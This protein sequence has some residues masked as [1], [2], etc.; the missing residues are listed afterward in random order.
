MEICQSPHFI[1][2]VANFI[3]WTGDE[4]S[5]FLHI[6]SKAM[7]SFS[8]AEN[9]NQSL[10]QLCNLRL[11]NWLLPHVVPPL[12]W[13][14]SNNGCMPLNSSMRSQ[15]SHRTSRVHLILSLLCFT[16]CQLMVSRVPSLTWCQIS[17][18]ASSSELLWMVLSRMDFW[19][20][21]CYWCASMTPPRHWKM[22]RI[23][24]K[25]K[26]NLRLMEELEH[27]TEQLDHSMVEGHEAGKRERGRVNE[28]DKNSNTIG[29]G[30]NQQEGKTMD[31]R[32]I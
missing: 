21:S 20:H 23:T 25:E 17:Y 11:S 27:R 28:T 16:N 32:A 15:P 9:H 19:E 31:E 30:L 3:L 26:T 18:T 22:S 14:Y 8:G 7:H 10:L 29:C 6:L 1:T 13:C 4:A 5:G 12:K 24:L 2:M